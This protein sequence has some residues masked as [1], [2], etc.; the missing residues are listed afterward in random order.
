MGSR[1]PERGGGSASAA[2][3]GGAGPPVADPCAAAPAVAGGTL[4]RGPGTLAW[5]P[6]AAWAAGG[7]LACGPDGAGRAAVRGAGRPTGAPVG[8]APPVAAAGGASS[9]R[10][11][12]S[13]SC[14]CT[15]DQVS[16]ALGTS[17]RAVTPPDRKSTR[18][19]SSHVEISY[20]VFC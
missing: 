12:A 20:A 14:S 13:S 3:P 19:N 18:L 10:T 2:R 4:A 16:S 1:S 17:T 5:G 8:A 11:A 7:A 9:G 15:A 6:D